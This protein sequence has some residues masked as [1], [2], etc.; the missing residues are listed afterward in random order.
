MG[1]TVAIGI[2]N[3]EKLIQDGYFYIDKTDFIREW[4]ESGDSVTLIT[5]PRRF[6]K[7][8]NMSMLEAFFSV[9]Y[10]GRGELFE[11]L[12]IWEDEKYRVLQ[13]TYPVIFLS[14]ANVKETDFKT[15]SYRIRQLLM[16]QYEKHAFLRE[17]NYLSEAEKDYFDRMRAGMSEEDAPLA[18]Y[19]L[20][21][22]LYRYYGKK[23][24]I[25]LDEYDTPMEEA[26]VYG[27]WEE[28][29]VFTRS[30][31][32][33]TFKT[34][35]YLE[36]AVMTGITRISKE[37]IFSDLN[38]LKVVTTTSDEYAV[39]FGFT[40]EEVFA[41]LEEYG[42]HDRKEEIKN[43]YD[44]FIFGKH[45]DIYNPWSILNFLDTGEIAPY[46]AN[47][48]SNRLISKL[49]QEGNGDI[50]KQFECLLR[51]QHIRSVIDEQ[52]VFD[53]LNG[54]EKAIWS[55]LLSSGYLKVV[56]RESYQDVPVGIQPR[57]ELAITNQEINLMFRGMVSDW[58]S[59]A[60]SDYNGFVKALLAGNL[61]EMNA[62]MN[63]VALKTFSCFDTGKNPSKQEPE[64]F[65]HGFVLGLLVELAG[66]YMVTSNG[67]SGFGRYDVMIEPKDV[68]KDDAFILEFKVH[69]L[70]EEGTLEDTVR[71]AH[72]QIEEKQYDAALL[73]RGIAA[74]HIRK[75]GF[76]FEGKRVLIG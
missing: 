16:K 29:A 69:D 55:L 1:K 10:A 53:R 22:F 24:I 40:E 51:G 72:A 43:W 35:P 36:R 45:R 4:L 63:Q 50:K 20:S 5:R 39:A 54:S 44:G 56:S 61:K 23:V 28:L 76:A 25:L 67:E 57:Y 34:N 11:G 70:S 71:A 32:N 41:S 37:S 15:T 73:A 3:F 13:G 12:S 62:Y 9:E 52:I 60:E 7:T 6:G 26:Y 42:Y 33:S 31:F 49:L 48:S 46:W 27:Y 64:R 19:Q 17:S 30:L 18:L 74:E 8:L 14:F 59:D 47:T 58:F 68:A 66:R 75:Y 65:Y 21:D 2:Q 38:N